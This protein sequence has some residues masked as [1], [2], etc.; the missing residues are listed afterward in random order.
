MDRAE[1]LGDLTQ[2]KD[3]QTASSA[4][5]RTQLSRDRQAA[6]AFIRHFTIDQIGPP[7]KGKP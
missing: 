3:R 5:G 7:R 6:A 2:L 4:S 1:V